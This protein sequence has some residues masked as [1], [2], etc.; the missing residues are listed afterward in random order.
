MTSSVRRVH[1]YFHFNIAVVALFLFLGGLWFIFMVLAAQGRVPRCQLGL[2]KTGPLS[3]R[4][5]LSED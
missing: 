2:S 1:M 3:T 5:T 4:E